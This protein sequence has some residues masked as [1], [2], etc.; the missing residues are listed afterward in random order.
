MFNGIIIVDSD[1]FLEM[2]WI[3]CLLVVVGV[4]VIGVEYVMMFLVLDV[5]VILIELC[6]SFFDFIDNGLIVEFIYE[7][8]ENGVDLCLGLVIEK[9]EDMGEYVEVSFENG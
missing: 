2:V 4:G 8:C 6:D 5:N 1:E 9:V 3:L 7:I